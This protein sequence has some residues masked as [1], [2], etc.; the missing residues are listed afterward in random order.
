MTTHLSSGDITGAMPYFSVASADDYQQSFFSLGTA[1]VISTINQIGGLTPVY[2]KNDTAE[3]F[4]TN[5]FAGQSVT[6]PVK[7]TK[8]NGAW[9][10]L[11]F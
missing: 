9:K 11:Q 1:N 10:V 3:Y 2:I 4:F 7:F 6:F 8:E 5:T